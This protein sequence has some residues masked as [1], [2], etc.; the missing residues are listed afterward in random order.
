[1]TLHH[2]LLEQAQH[3][4]LREPKKPKQASLRRAVSAA[5]YALFYF[6]LF[7]ATLLFFPHEPAALR[8]RAS[9]AFSHGEARSACVIFSKSGIKDLTIDPLETELIDM[10]RT[11]IELQEA[12][13]R[14]DYDLNES[15][16]RVQ[17]VGIVDQARQ[18]MS[19]WKVIKGSP[20]ANVFLAALLLHNRWSSK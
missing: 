5:Y 10:A 14:A 2:D 3:L 15:F 6:L 8:S 11:F 19:N 17:V 4:A 20:N 16:D 1:L 12:R 7:E 18:A 9:R 13:H